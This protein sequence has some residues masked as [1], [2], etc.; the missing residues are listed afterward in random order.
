[1]AGLEHTATQ[2]L[3][4]AGADDSELQLIEVLCAALALVP[5]DSRPRILAYLSDRYGEEGS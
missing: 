5:V 4:W 3:F 1:M 2:Y